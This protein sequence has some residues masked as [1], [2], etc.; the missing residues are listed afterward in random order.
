VQW[1]VAVVLAHRVVEQCEQEEDLR[2]DTRRLA[3]EV[4][5]DPADEL[6]V[7]LAVDARRLPCAAVF[8]RRD[9]C[10]EVSDRRHNAIV[11][12]SAQ[13]GHPCVTVAPAY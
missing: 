7:V 5:S 13:G 3:G 6:P 9:E 2:V 8:D 10:I 4:G 12:L 11:T 1:I